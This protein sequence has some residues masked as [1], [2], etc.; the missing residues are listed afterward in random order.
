MK[1]IRHEI[2][3]SNAITND[4]VIDIVEKNIAE[5]LINLDHGYSLLCEKYDGTEFVQFYS[6]HGMAVRDVA[7]YLGLDVQFD[8]LTNEDLYKE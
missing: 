5:A 4:Q 2:Y 1:K 6:G 7:E 8:P 3:E